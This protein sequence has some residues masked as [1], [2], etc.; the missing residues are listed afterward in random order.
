MAP[1]SSPLLFDTWWWG[2]S[3]NGPSAPRPRDPLGGDF[4][5]SG[6]WDEQVLACDFCLIIDM[7]YH[8]QMLRTIVAEKERMTE[9]ERIT[10]R[11][12]AVLAN[13]AMPEWERL[14]EGKEFLEPF[15]IPYETQHKL[16]IERDK[17]R[18]LQREREKEAAEKMLDTEVIPEPTAVESHERQ[19]EEE[20]LES[21][22]L[23]Y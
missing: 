6:V 5:G 21:L 16:R 4:I 10:L 20:L 13:D 2:I 3:C 22:E 15:E 23:N 8:Q 18:A 12:W 17:L 1:P 14:Q 19:A 7:R 9:H 11:W